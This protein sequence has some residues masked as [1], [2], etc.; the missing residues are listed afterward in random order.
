[1]MMLTW[2]VGFW[3]MLMILAIVNVNAR[4]K[5]FGPHKSNLSVQQLST[6]LFSSAVFFVSFVL[7][8]LGDFTEPGNSFIFL[9]LI[10][11]VLIISFEFITGHFTFSNA[12]KKLFAD[13]SLLNGRIWLL[14]LI[15]TLTAPRII[16]KITEG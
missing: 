9:G 6:L 11:L 10:W 12:W 15:N 2:G 4:E 8:G 16:Y 3:L 13:Y 7:V 1:M 14:V 5:L